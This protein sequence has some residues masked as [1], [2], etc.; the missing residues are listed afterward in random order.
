A[1]HALRMR[2]VRDRKQR[3]SYCRYGEVKPQKTRRQS[4]SLAVN[5]SHLNSLILSRDCASKAG[6]CNAVAAIWLHDCDEFESAQLTRLNEKQQP[7]RQN[8][9]VA[10]FAPCPI[11]MMDLTPLEPK[12]YLGH[13]DTG[14]GERCYS[15]GQE[16]KGKTCV[17]SSFLSPV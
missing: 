13:I 2:D 14:D 15:Q 7:A 3:E 4:R 12:P 5:L 6:I 1:H 11:S 16:A 8:P 9:S 17:P 10:L